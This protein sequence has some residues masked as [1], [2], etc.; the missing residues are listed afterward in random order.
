MWITRSAFTRQA[1]RE[2]LQ[3]EAVA[4]LERKHRQGYQAK[5]AAPGEFDGW[6][7]EQRW[8]E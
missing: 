1:L 8:P 4:D 6:D 3:R 7:D 2:A 5:P